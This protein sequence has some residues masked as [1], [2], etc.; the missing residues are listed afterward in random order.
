MLILVKNSD[1]VLPLFRFKSDIV[2]AKDINKLYLRL[3]KRVA[4]AGKI[5]SLVDGTLDDIALFIK[6]GAKH[7]GVPPLQP[8]INGFFCISPRRENATDTSLLNLLLI[9][10]CAVGAI[11]PQ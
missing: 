8:S 2:K 1:L 5:F 4:T 9:I 6:R 11:D 3:S 10:K 7:G